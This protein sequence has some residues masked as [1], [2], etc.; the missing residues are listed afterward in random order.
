[1]ERDDGATGFVELERR[2]QEVKARL[3]ELPQACAEPPE[4]VC[5]LPQERVDAHPT[6]A[7]EGAQDEE[8]SLFPLF[9]VEEVKVTTPSETPE[10][11]VAAFEFRDESQLVVVKHQF[12]LLGK[13]ANSVVYLGTISRPTDGWKEHHVAVKATRLQ[14]TRAEEIDRLIAIVRLWHSIAHPGFVRCYYT[15]LFPANG[16]KD[17]RIDMYAALELASGGTLDALLKRRE[18]LNDSVVRT[19]L[20]DVLRTLQYMHDVVGA[21]HNDVKPQ[22]IL[23][24][25]GA[26]AGEV[27]YKLSDVDCMCPCLRCLEGSGLEEWK[28]VKKEE[29]GRRE[30]IYGSAPYMSPESCRGIPFLYT[31]DIWSVGVLTYQ[32]STGRL[33]WTPLELQ[34]PSMILHGYRQSSSNSFGPV[35]DEFDQGSG[36]S[37]SDKLK[38][39]VTLCLLKNSTERPTAAELLQHPFLSGANA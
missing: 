4:G 31:N 23:L 14:L 13:G 32:L 38:D 29:V 8:E 19:V 15:G 22:N 28:T 6:G 24:F 34:I 7:E 12:K 11:S 33:P 36:Q 10:T 16:T 25:G 1:M 9:K 3:L 18:R 2:L 21:V 20:L 35:L 30:G 26:G 5:E 39:F 17:G 37:Y 27:R